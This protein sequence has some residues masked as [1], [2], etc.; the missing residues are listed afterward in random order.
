MNHAVS[1]RDRWSRFPHISFWAG[2]CT[3][4]GCR[5]VG[6]VIPLIKFRL[7]VRTALA[8]QGTFS[9]RDQN[10]CDS[11]SGRTT[12][13]SKCCPCPNGER[14]CCPHQQTNSGFLANVAGR[15]HQQHQQWRQAGNQQQPLKHAHS[16]GPFQRFRGARSSSKP[17]NRRTT[18]K[19][20]ISSNE[21]GRVY[22][23]SYTHLTL[24]TTHDV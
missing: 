3:G 6:S 17:S 7:N 11:G 22:P 15:Q 12:H 13:A 1:H 9:G 5:F 20:T 2:A 19:S 14:R 21:S 10:R 4:S 8:T 16:R 18:K 24:P 23:V